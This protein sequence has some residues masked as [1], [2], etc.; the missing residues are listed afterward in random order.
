MFK[1]EKDRKRIGIC[2]TCWY[3]QK[4]HPTVKKPACK[5]SC[6]GKV[7]HLRNYR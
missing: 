5:C 4:H 7:T 6:N 3:L 1:D 2:K